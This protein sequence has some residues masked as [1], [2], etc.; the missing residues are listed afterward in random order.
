MTSASGTHIQDNFI[1]EKWWQAFLLLSGLSVVIYLMT[2]Q[3]IL[4]TTLGETLFT[5]NAYICIAFIGLALGGFL[6]GELSHRYPNHL[7]KIF[8]IL[9]LV[10][11][12]YGLLSYPLVRA[13]GTALTRVSDSA[14]PFLLFFLLMVPTM[15][16]GA[17]LPLLVRYI[18][19]RKG[20]VGGVLSRMHGFFLLGMALGTVLLIFILYF[21][22]N[23]FVALFFASMFNTLAA[24]LLFLKVNNKPLWGRR[25]S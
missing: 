9:Q 23:C 2:W 12:A 14:L 10:L 17:L 15:A 4:F 22:F 24:Y 20:D 5:R 8:F 19:Q 18:H 6:G 7:P 21:L 13:V 3:R 11:G 1:T 16:M 25:L